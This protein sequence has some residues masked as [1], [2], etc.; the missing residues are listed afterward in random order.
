ML[1]YLYASTS[2]VLLHHAASYKVCCERDRDRQRQTERQ[3]YRH[4][5]TDR[6]RQADRLR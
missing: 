2:I 3:K 6:Q 5:E 1:N 4:T